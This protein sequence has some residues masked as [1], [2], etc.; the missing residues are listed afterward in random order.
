MADRRERGVLGPVR[1][2]RGYG[3]IP[4]SRK[5]ATVEISIP[6]TNG[7]IWGEEVSVDEAEFPYC[8]RDSLGPSPTAPNCCCPFVSL[9]DLDVTSSDGSASAYLGNSIS[10]GWGH[11]HVSGATD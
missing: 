1:C 6:P 10:R 9:R 4:R 3:T 8:G 7:P 11:R 5:L 2:W